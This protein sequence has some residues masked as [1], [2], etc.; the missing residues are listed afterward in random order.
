MSNAELV[1]R[2]EGGEN[3]FALEQDIGEHFAHLHAVRPTV[4]PAYCNS[5]DAAVALVERVRPGVG[6]D[7]IRSPKGMPQGSVGDHSADAPT[8]AAALV[9]AL[10][11]AGV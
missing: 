9:A 8:P 6:W 11:K 10:L 2:L 1:A 3:T 7:I 5:L 4:W